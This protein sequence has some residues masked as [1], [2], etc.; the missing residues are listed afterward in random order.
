MSHIFR[1]HFK[2]GPYDTSVNTTDRQWAT[3]NSYVDKKSGKKKFGKLFF[4]STID[5]LR[6]QLLKIPLNKRDVYEFAIDGQPTRLFF[7]I[8]SVTSHDIDV[9]RIVKHAFVFARRTMGWNVKF[10]V[11]QLDASNDKKFSR[12]VIIK[13]IQEDGTELWFKDVRSVGAFV[14]RCYASLPEEEDSFTNAI[15]MGVYTRNREFRIPGAGKCGE[16]RYLRLMKGDKILS[17]DETLMI[18]DTLLIQDH[19]ITDHQTIEVTEAN[20]LPAQSRVISISEYR[21]LWFPQEGD[22]DIPLCDLSEVINKRKRALKMVDRPAPLKK[23]RTETTF[24]TSLMPQESLFE[25]PKGYDIEEPLDFFGSVLSI[26]GGDSNYTVSEFLDP[27][28]LISVPFSQ[29]SAHVASMSKGQK[30]MLANIKANIHKKKDLSAAEQAALDFIGTNSKTSKTLSELCAIWL[31]ELTLD[32]HVTL[33]Q[34]LYDEGIETGFIFS[35]PRTLLCHKKGAEHKSNKIFFVFD[36][37]KARAT[38]QCHDTQDC[39]S[40]PGVEII[41]PLKIRYMMFLAKTW[42]E[43]YLQT[44][45]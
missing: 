11:Y 33:V 19:T 41:L 35:C 6:T 45:F 21:K 40:K 31:M 22:E 32:S 42:R 44:F 18:F 4:R 38:Q 28:E 7:D 27:N 13:M 12:H 14:R 20:G 39:G 17:P 23:Q 16:G 37:P 15:D 24:P 9:N 26:M 34:T 29:M 36:I 10:H 5:N 8:E 2:C 1:R 3:D 25:V 30:A 43:L